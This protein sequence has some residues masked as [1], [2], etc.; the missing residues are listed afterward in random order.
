MT[1]P[2]ISCPRCS[3]PIQP[4]GRFCTEC[5]SPVEGATCAG[6]GG[7]LTP[8]AKFCHRCG[9]AVGA[10]L[11]TVP[12]GAVPTP[13]RG[14]ESR[15]PWIIGAVAALAVVALLIAQTARQAPASEGPV[16][17]GAMGAVG[18][19]GGA[20]PMGGAA[21]GSAPTGVPQRWQNFAPG[22]SFPAH[23]AHCAPSTGAP[24]S[25]Q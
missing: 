18:G 13:A 4:D 21:A 25:V 2:A 23:P 1:A 14:P 24:H 9:A 20:P 16:A 7:P 15:L 11:G 8:G 5:G 12:G 6:C 3:S 19:F 22:V 10:L 17:A